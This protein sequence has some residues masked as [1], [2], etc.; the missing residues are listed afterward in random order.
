MLVKRSYL[1]LLNV[2][3]NIRLPY[4]WSF[5][6]AITV[7]L[8]I[9]I[10]VQ[11]FRSYASYVSLYVIKYAFTHCFDTCVSSLIDKESNFVNLERNLRTC[12]SDFYIFTIPISLMD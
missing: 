4:F 3:P 1:T 5:L 9:F 10:F 6:S 12:K 8:G 2:L 11:Y 7:P